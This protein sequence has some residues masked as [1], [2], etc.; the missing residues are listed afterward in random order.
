MA[1]PS[2]H[3]KLYKRN[4]IAAKLN[5]QKINFEET[6]FGL[7]FASHAN[8]TIDVLFRPWALPVALEMEI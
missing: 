5:F 6:L 4:S 3:A 1:G 8:N 2:S 7:T